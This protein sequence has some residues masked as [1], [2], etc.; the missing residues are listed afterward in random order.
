M[1][2][3]LSEFDRDSLTAG[4]IT[5]CKLLIAA[6][7]SEIQPVLPGVS[8]Y[9]VGKDGNDISHPQFQKYI[10][11]LR[12]QK[13]DKTVSAHQMGTCRMGSSPTTSVTDTNGKVWGYNG[14]FICDTSLFPTA[15]G[16]FPMITCMALAE[17]VSRRI[18]AEI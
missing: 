15:T 4:M 1:D 14:L 18:L 3:E 2:Y 12:R 5:M 13:I 10:N 16:V 9:K 6:G 8:P 17:W 7:A 11:Y